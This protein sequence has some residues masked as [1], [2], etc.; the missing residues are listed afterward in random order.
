MFAFPGVHVAP[1]FILM[2]NNTRPHEDLLID[3]FLKSENIRRMDLPARSPDLNPIEHAWETLGR[4]IA[5]HNPPPS[6]NYPGN[7]NSVAEQARPNTTRTDKL[8]Y[9]KY[10]IT[11]GGLNSYPPNTCK[12]DPIQDPSFAPQL[13][14][15]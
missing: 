12:W 8:P 6:E 5:T 13:V 4:A 14:V 10:N 15:H 1:E 2:D 7:E 3:E 9:F 11:L